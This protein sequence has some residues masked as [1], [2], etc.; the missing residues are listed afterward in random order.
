VAKLLI[1]HRADVNTKDKHGMTALSWATTN[2]Q[3]K[4]IELLKE[5]VRKE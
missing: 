1:S 4:V 3:A 2:Q 5:A